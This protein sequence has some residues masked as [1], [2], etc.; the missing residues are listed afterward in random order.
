LLNLL[1]RKTDDPNVFPDQPVVAARVVSGALGAL[2]V[3]RAIHL[4]AKLRRRAVE[5]EDVGTERVLA[6]EMEAQLVAP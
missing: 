2:G 3:Y 6:T 1:D 5:I 4:D